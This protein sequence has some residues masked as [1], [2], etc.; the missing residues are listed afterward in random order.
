VIDDSP[1]LDVVSEE[2]DKQTS[3][4]D[5]GVDTDSESEHESGSKRDTDVI[6]VEPEQPPAPDNNPEAESE[7][8]PDAD[9]QFKRRV[10]T[11]IAEFDD[12]EIKRATARD[13][14]ARA[15]T[16]CY[17]FVFPE[18]EVQG[19]RTTLYTYH[20]PSGVYEPRGERFVQKR[21]EA[22]AGDFV[23]N[24]TVNEIVGKIKR[25]AIERGENFM[26]PPEKLVVT[27]GI[28]DLHTG[29][30]KPHTPAEYHRTYVDVRWNPDA[31]EPDAVDEFLHEIVVDSDVTTLYRLI[32]HTLYKEYIGEKAA[33]LIGSGKNGK[34]L[35]INFIEKFIG[36]PNTAHRELQDFDND[37][38]AANNL[39][40]KLANLATE[41]GEQELNNTTTFKKLTGRDTMDAQVKYESPVTFENYATMMFSTNNMPVFGQDNYAIWRRWVYLDFPY[42]FDASDPTAKDPE[43]KSD[44]LNR[45]TTDEQFE[46]LLV[47]CQQEIQRWHEDST[48][49]FFADAM[50]PS[51]VRDKM[52]KAAEP[53][54]NFA[55]TCLEVGDHED[56]FVGK[57]TV[58][59]CYREYADLED[60]PTVPENVFG[61]RLIGLRDFSIESKQRTLNGS[62]ETVYV[63]IELSSRGRQ[64]LDIDAPSDDSQS[65]VG[66]TETVQTTEVVMEQLRTMTD[67]TDG[68]PVPREGLAWSCVSDSI[69]YR[70]AQN[71]IDKL[72]QETNRIIVK[73]GDVLL[74]E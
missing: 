45:L 50:S 51:A 5:G 56:T 11:A 48:E 19:W 15:F 24:Q 8:E 33:I 29:T 26:A 27:N 62:V 21:L 25:R 74:A 32:A 57:D 67:A 61:E 53:I 37:D 58:R 39:K 73:D 70:Q 55:S 14:I 42:S 47:R 66:D 16:D 44:I 60:L 68:D 34:S 3:T 43:P 41:I 23:T 10:Q 30:L 20:P 46:A 18:E 2:T 1:S 17:D 4:T 7:S 72:K 59:A 65:Q 36:R 35:F 28:L 49:P 52:K 9:Q 54:Y 22:V 71:A 13:R 6:P 69:S 38:F 31:G 12:D 40:G 63:G 64:V